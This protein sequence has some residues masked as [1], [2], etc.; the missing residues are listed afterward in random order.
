LAP[1]ASLEAENPSN[2]ICAADPDLV[3]GRGNELVRGLAWQAI[4][5]AKVLERVLSIPD[6]HT[7]IGGNHHSVITEDH[8]I[9]DSGGG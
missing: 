9:I 1:R 8:Q 3:T 4:E 7:A 6:G 2:T 5:E